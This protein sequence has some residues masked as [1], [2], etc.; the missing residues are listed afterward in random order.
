MRGF[1][2]ITRAKTD[3]EKITP[4]PRAARFGG[5]FHPYERI[6]RN[7]QYRPL[8]IGQIVSNLGDTIHYVALVVLLFR[9]TGSGVVLAALALAQ[10]AATLTM[11]PIAGVIVDRF[12]RRGV[13]VAADLAR[14][15]LATSLAFTANA[16]TAIALAVG[17][18]VCGVP[19]GP[20][21]RAL[22]PALVDEDALLAA[23]TV[24]WSTEQATQI[25]AAAG[26]G[27]LL[28]TFGTTPA[29]LFNAATF[30]FSAA[31]LL[32]LRGRFRPIGS[33]K[34]HDTGQGFWADAHAGLRYARRDAFVGPLLLVQ[35]LASFATGGTAALLVVLSTRHLRLQPT[36]FAWLLLAIGIGALVGP[37]LLPRLLG[38]DPRLMFWPYVWRG[39]GDILLGTM[40]A[41]PVAFA[42]LVVYGIGTSTGAVTYSTVLQRRVPD[43][44][45][46][47]VFATLDVVWAAGEIASIGV[48]GYV[49][50][51]I[52]IA[53]VYIGGGVILALA[54]GIG[55]LRVVP[56]AMP[57]D[58]HAD[59]KT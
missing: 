10:I 14:A 53:A 31:M 17:I 38:A 32:R 16:P 21:A 48:A 58:T 56:E 1:R 9:L 46:G 2:K 3:T 28:L 19:F 45:R 51:R 39:A 59:I 8:W 27:G 4:P 37:F 42:V 41:L 30:L 54:G 35:A 40:T 25:I 47:R 24:G 29:F 15:T 11:G 23:N 34:E 33:A 52:G 43:A 44:M 50:D 12:D 55:L 7:A 6:V 57:M 13:M 26:A 49:S 22:L 36:Q 5:L 18:A 20:A